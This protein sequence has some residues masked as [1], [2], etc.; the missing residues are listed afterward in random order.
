MGVGTRVC[1]ALR[2]RWSHWSRFGERCRVPLRRPRAGDSTQSKS[3]PGAPYIRRVC[4]RC[5][6]SARD[7]SRSRLRR[8]GPRPSGH[9]CCGPAWCRA[10]RPLAPWRRIDRDRLGHGLGGLHG[11]GRS[12]LGGESRSGCRLARRQERERI[13]VA[14]GVLC[15]ADPQLHVRLVLWIVAHRSDDLA[16]SG[17]VAG[18]DGDRAEVG[19]GHDPSVRRAEREGLAVGRQRSGD[20]TTPEAQA[21]VL[22]RPRPRRYRA[23]VT[24]AV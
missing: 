18:R 17:A 15:A 2:P 5:S 14:A 8:V 22:G 6:G 16:L 12:R 23:S 7:R 21:R 20:V 19:E 10:A 13:H 1:L 4:L 3:S 11:S 9:H 24:E